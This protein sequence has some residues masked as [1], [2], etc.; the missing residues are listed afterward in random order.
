MLRV[1]KF[2]PAAGIPRRGVGGWPLRRLL[3]AAL[4]RTAILAIR[5]AARLEAADAHDREKTA[6]AAPLRPN[7]PGGVVG[8][9]LVE[10]VVYLA[11]AA[12]F[13]AGLVG[14]FIA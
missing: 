12:L 7:A 13:V 10:A 9:R 14:V 11:M 8:V 1:L 5:L 2:A 3:R 6:G 4:F